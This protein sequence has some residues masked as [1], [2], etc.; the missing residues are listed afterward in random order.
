MLSL[1]N[2]RISRVLRWRKRVEKY[3]SKGFTVGTIADQRLEEAYRRN[4]VLSRGA[5]R[6]TS[7]IN[8]VDDFSR[9]SKVNS[10]AGAKPRNP[11]PKSLSTTP[12]PPNHLSPSTHTANGYAPVGNPRLALQNLVIPI[13]ENSDTDNMPVPILRKVTYGGSPNKLARIGKGGIGIAAE[14]P[15]GSL[16]DVPKSDGRDVAYNTTPCIENM[17]SKDTTILRTAAGSADPVI[18]TPERASAVQSKTSSPLRFKLVNNSPNKVT[19]SAIVLKSS[20]SKDELTR[21]QPTGKE[22]ACAIKPPKMDLPAKVTAA[23][24]TRA[25][26]RKLTSGTA[27]IGTA[28]TKETTTHGPKKRNVATKSVLAD[29]EASSK[30]SDE[31]IN[32]ATGK[33]EIVTGNPTTQKR[34]A[35]KISINKPDTSNLVESKLAPTLATPNKRVRKSRTTAM[36]SPETIME[37][38]IEP[39]TTIATTTAC[40][41]RD[42]E[43]EDEEPVALDF[44]PARNK[45]KYQSWADPKSP[46]WDVIRFLQCDDMLAKD[47]LL[48]LP[49]KNFTY[50]D[51]VNQKL[52]NPNKYAY[53]KPKAPKLIPHPKLADHIKKGTA[54]EMMNLYYED[55]PRDR[56]LPLAGKIDIPE[57]GSGWKPGPPGRGRHGRNARPKGVLPASGSYLVVENSDDSSSLSSAPSS[58]SDS[59]P[60]FTTASSPAHASPTRKMRKDPADRIFIAL[61]GLA[62]KYDVLTDLDIQEETFHTRPSI[63]LPVPDHIKAIL[64]DDWENVTKN[65]QLV[66]LPAANPVNKI[67]DDYLDYEQPRRQAGTAQADILVEVIAGLKEYFEKTLGRILL[68]RFERSQY[69]E[70]REGFNKDG[71]DFAGKSVGDTYGAEHLCRLIVTLPELIAQTNMDAQ[72][73]NRLREELTKLTIWIGRNV[74]KYFVAEYETPSPEYVEKARSG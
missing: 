73:S 74:T 63:Q 62:A 4:S 46:D 67:L 37:D 36:D 31:A 54:T 14:G 15:R 25:S 71:G 44:E 45:R 51:E 8:I 9:F 3:N 39:V 49:P 57:T 64:V 65:Q 28:I 72:S 60:S 19:S 30:A 12:L 23:P 41:S 33:A 59:E 42:G 55:L 2:N 35:S 20:I 40:R 26:E 10:G 21:T 17:A 34:K 5:K 43:E 47:N 22:S 52:R 1:Q 48:Q 61:P 53:T 16:S 13:D 27:T 11:T 58:T 66:P 50:V 68:Y 6:L 7:S 24:V 38:E 29:V 32:K 18:K 70:V 69:I 56:V